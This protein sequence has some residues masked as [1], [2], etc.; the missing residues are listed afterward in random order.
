MCQCKSKTIPSKGSVM[1][2]KANDFSLSGNAL[3]IIAAVSMVLDHVGIMFFPKIIVFRILGRLAFPIFAFMI[4]EGCRYTRSKL[5]YF[6]GIF[7]LAFL[8]QSVYFIA[9]RSTDLSILVTFPLSVLVIYALQDFKS[10]A[11]DKSCPGAR[12]LI[13]CLVLLLAVLGVY[14]LSRIAVLDY[15]FWGC[16]CPVF[17]ALLHPADR[18]GGTWRSEPRVHALAM[19]LP[20]AMLSLQMQW[21]QPFCFASVLLLM[22]YR[23]RRG[24]LNMKYFFYIFYPA[25]LALLQGLAYIIP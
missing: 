17:A 16:M 8:C 23:G 6:S 21:V 20:L 3:K 7:I 11:Y 19:C 22:F 9:M 25:H 2:S 12:K 24:K 15:G 14:I 1:F 18:S 13:S 5:R 4:A 10:K